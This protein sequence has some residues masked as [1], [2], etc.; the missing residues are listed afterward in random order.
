ELQAKLESQKDDHAR[1][2]FA[3]KDTGIGINKKQ[4]EK[5]FRSFTQA[6]GS[7]TRKYGGT[8]LG[9]TISSQLVEKMD[10]E[11]QVDSQVGQGSQFYFT[12]D[13]EIVSNPIHEHKAINIKNALVVDDNENNRII[14][15]TILDKWGISSILARKGGEGLKK[16]RN[17]RDTIDLVIIDY[18]MP[19][20][21]GLELAEKMTL[22]KER[23]PGILLYSSS[24]KKIT[25]KNLQKYGIDKKLEKPVKQKDLYQVLKTFSDDNLVEYRS[26]GSSQETK[27]FEKPIK[28]LIAEDNEMNMMLAT[29]IIKQVL[30][31]AEIIKT[32]NGK[33]ALEKFKKQDPKLILMDIQMPVMDGIEATRKI[34]NIDSNIP[35][36][37]LT[38]GVLK[39]EK[40]ECLEAG[41]DHF[42][43]KP[44]EQNEL[45]KCLL[46]NVN[47]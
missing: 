15:K 34:K 23:H 6:D 12:L 18:H 24:N 7:T 9:L 21:N 47:I 8:G 35:I 1:V 4:K 17:N 22:N 20:M 36:I 42:M 10:G 14:L 41:I 46:D 45:K 30:P 27:I 16:Y 32:K 2:R 13:L 43:G 33:E 26:G 29:N 5:I 31:K 28:L 37:A 11:L 44:I 25:T 3:V 39:E 38:A 19:D 40:E